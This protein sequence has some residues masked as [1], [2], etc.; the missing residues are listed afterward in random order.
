MERKRPELKRILSQFCELNE[1]PKTSPNFR[2]KRIDPLDPLMRLLG[3]RSMN[4]HLDV[5]HLGLRVL[6]ILSR[7]GENRKT[8]TASHVRVI[9]QVLR[10]PP[11]ERI[12]SECTNVV[13]N[14]C[15]ERE[16]VQKVLD[17]DGV[18]P[19]VNFLSAK[20]PA[21]QA[22]ASGAIQ[23]ISFQQQGKLVVRDFG[24][25]P[26]LIKLLDSSLVKVRTRAIGAIHNLS[27]D[28]ESVKLVR[29]CQGIP[30]IVQ[31]LHAR[32]TAICGSAAG[33]VQNLAREDASREIILKLDAVDPLTN[34]LVG[35]DIPTAVCSIGALMNLIG[36]QMGP[37]EPSNARRAEF[38]KLLT[39][40]LVAG[41]A[42]HG[43]YSPNSPMDAE[44]FGPPPSSSQGARA[45]L[46]E[47][48]TS[49][50][51]SKR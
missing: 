2:R 36:P 20:D 23:S 40:S 1:N 50:S 6:K 14:I 15:Y 5:L 30:T 32:E 33:A 34:L 19:L 28:L 13:L 16:N 18:A 49:G 47:L 9:V 48:E 4:D 21:L 3:H 29:Q 8:V 24:A 46:D 7:K 22:N 31:M 17:M 37:N 51:A 35:A 39:T 38:R 45:E 12:A 26:A 44:T 42:F 43:L 27:T 11:E 41:L 25:V 10:D